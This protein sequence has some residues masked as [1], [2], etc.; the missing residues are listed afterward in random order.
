MKPRTYWFFFLCLVA[1]LCLKFLAPL[2]IYDVPL[3]VDP[4]IYRYLFLK[5]AVALPPLEI[6]PMEPWARDHP[7]GLF[8][9]T[10]L[11][12]KAGLSA[13]ML[14]GWFWN[15]F[16]IFLLVILALSTE[17]RFG[18]LSSVLVLL[19]GALSVPYFDGF[20]AM[21]IKTYVALGFMVSAFTLIDR[22]SWW[23]CIP[24]VLVLI[25][26]QQVGLLL[27]MSLCLYWVL[28]LIQG[29][30]SHAFL[31]LP[32]VFIALMALGYILNP[33]AIDRVLSLH[34]LPLLTS[35]GGRGN[36]GEFG[37]TWFYM[38]T[39]GVLFALGVFGFFATLR[40]DKCTQWHCTVLCCLFFVVL[41]MMFY[42]RFLLLLDFFLLPFA[43]YGLSLLFGR[44]RSIL[45]R[46]TLCGVLVLLQLVPS[47]RVFAWRTPEISK[48][49]FDDIQT[50]SAHVPENAALLSLDA[51][52][53]YFL[54]GWVPDAV[55]SGPGL[56][57][58]SWTEDQWN[59]FF[60]GN[61]DDRQ[62]L[63]SYLQKP[64]YVYIPSTVKKAE[65]IRGHSCLSVTE[66]QT[67]FENTCVLSGPGPGP[68]PS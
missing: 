48:A 17:R 40:T 23:A 44:Y 52:S 46:A 49:H 41:Q 54:V 53:S 22:R 43:G 66:I 36:P 38:L 68:D 16:C 6:A 32:V 35:I 11:L 42:R 57:S 8:F 39:N 25:T 67:L 29:E 18:Q 58:P 45:G 61:E 14:I 64:S 33:H 37:D 63:F 9:F 65:E 28:N 56:F 21:Y 27:I 26:S 19:L 51:V 20:T 5:H 30:R 59:I 12:I 34:L 2:V 3:G 31:L 10:S 55:V 62:T 24:I 7:L 60:N 47:V 15:V 50:V 13:D 1:L 4:G